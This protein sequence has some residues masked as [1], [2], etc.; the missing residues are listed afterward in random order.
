SPV[1]SEASEPSGAPVAPAAP[2]SAAGGTSDRP[3]A[4]RPDDRGDRRGRRSRRRRNKGRGFPESKYAELAPAATPVTAPIEAEATEPDA[5][6]PVGPVETPLVLPGESLAKYRGAPRIESPAIRPSSVP[7]PLPTEEELDV[8][9]EQSVYEEP[10]HYPPE[11][12][13]PD[14]PAHAAPDGSLTAT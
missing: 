13:L 8:Q 2:A 1:G 5:A 14:A 12:A 10:I 4:D 11:N 9:V 6:A 3:P 7:P